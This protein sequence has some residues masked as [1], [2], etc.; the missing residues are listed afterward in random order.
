[1]S[2]EMK[3]DKLA[4][5]CSKTPFIGAEPAFL[6]PQ[7]CI[8]SA[9]WQGATV[10]YSR[11]WGMAAIK[12]SIFGSTVTTLEEVVCD[13]RLNDLLKFVSRA[14][15]CCKLSPWWPFSHWEFSAHCT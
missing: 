11:V 1:M 5:L 8:V 3:A 4:K 14:A 12:Y 13:R 15:L 9:V 2:G 7:C 6:L 10:S